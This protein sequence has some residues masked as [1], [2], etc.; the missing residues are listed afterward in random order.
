MKKL[1]NKGF[2]HIEIFVVVAAFA[3][4]GIVGGFVWQNSKSKDSLADNSYTIWKTQG[5]DVRACRPY[6]NDPRIAYNA[7]QAYVLA[8][9]DQ[10]RSKF[11]KFIVEFTNTVNT[12]QKYDAGGEAL[13]TVRE[14][15]NPYGVNSLMYAKVYK[16]NGIRVI[17]HSVEVF[18]IKPCP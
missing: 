9:T 10:S 2:G 3:V 4:I 16:N 13:A 17:P 15:K 1:N 8:T 12:S 18:D 7:I 6:S 14:Y 5:Y 11:L